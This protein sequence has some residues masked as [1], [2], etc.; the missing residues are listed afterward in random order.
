MMGALVL[1]AICDPLI[2]EWSDHT[3]SRWGWR[4]PF[5]YASAVPL[6]IAFYFLWNPPLGWS[7]GSLL[8]YLIALLVTVRLLLSLYEIPS[9]A[10]GP[11]LTLDYD[12]RTSLMS[13]R[14]LFGVIG[15][16][17]IVFLALRVFLRKDAAHPLGIG[18]AAATRALVAQYLSWDPC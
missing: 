11:E 5:M 1:D 6:A 9:Q 17:S 14:F 13:W 2:G 15:G 12:A 18:I 7:H 16:S 4:H 3:R 8:I 10:L